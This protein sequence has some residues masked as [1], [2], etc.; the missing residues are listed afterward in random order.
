MLR[1][2]L[3]VI[4]TAVAV[5]VGT[6]A[7][8][9]PVAAPE[10]STGPPA[11]LFGTHGPDPH[12]P[13]RPVE[14]LGQDLDPPSD[15]A[16]YDGTVAT[17]DVVPDISS[18][19]ATGGLGLPSFHAIYV[20]GSDRPS[21]L[22]ELAAMFQDDLRRASSLLTEQYG[23]ALRIDERTGA[24][25]EQYVDITDF[26]SASTEAELSNDLVFRQVVTEL[27]GQFSAK[28]K[29]YVV[30]VDADVP[31]CGQATL[32]QDVRRSSANGNELSSFALIYRP[33]DA[34][35]SDGG[36]C[37]SGT[38]LHEIGHAIGALQ[39]VAPHAYDGAHCNDSEADIMCYPLLART[40]PGADDFLTEALSSNPLPVIAVWDHNR[41]DYWDPGGGKHPWWTTNLSR[42]LCPPAGCTV[43]NASPGY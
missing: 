25:G 43:P 27:S 22:P 11:H 16:T 31:A 33:Y 3:G 24:D 19:V 26:T 4:V 35:D 36:F 23:Y 32:H 41:D 28:N 29:K 42:F 17:E 9:V 38:V 14:V 10:V 15:P 2:L 5:L 6:L 1:K 34:T 40:Q 30:W 39:R 21:R 8:S 37:R 18:S 20:H 12:S 13:Q 7:S